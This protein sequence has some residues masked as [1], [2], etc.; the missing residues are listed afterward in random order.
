MRER[1]S[2]ILIE[3]NT[4]ANV[5]RARKAGKMQSKLDRNM[6]RGSLKYEKTI[7]FSVVN[8]IKNISGEII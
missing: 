3:K 1:Y 8:R 5:I 7:L 4:V 2:T 6:K